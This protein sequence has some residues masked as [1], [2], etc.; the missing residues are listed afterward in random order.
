M[1]VPRTR[2]SSRR[3]GKI[4]VTNK[5][6][7]SGRALSVAT[8]SG[9]PK[10]RFVRAFDVRVRFE[11]PDDVLPN[12][13]DHIE[14]WYVRLGRFMYRFDTRPTLAV[15]DVRVQRLQ[16]ISLGDICAKG[17]AASIYDFKPVTSGF[18][19]F[20]TLWD[21]ING[22]PRANGAAISW[23]ANPWVVAT[24]FTVHKCNIDRMRA[25]A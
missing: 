12:N 2:R 18:S 13:R 8:S 6:V 10:Q 19:A 23:A 25:V 15:T 24:T 5:S 1:T 3:P 17:L 16:D 9:K 21:S 4:W 20:R 7:A 14:D 22:K 11:K